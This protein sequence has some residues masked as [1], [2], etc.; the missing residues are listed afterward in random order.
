MGR[1][2]GALKGRTEQA[3]DFARWLRRITSGVKVRSLEEEFPYGK[4]SWS[5]FR[6][7]TRL[8][9]RGLVEQVAARYLPE[10]VMRGRQLEEGLRLLAAAQQ[11]A[12]TPAGVADLPMPA[13]GPRRADTVHAALLRLDDARLRQ[14]EAMQKLAASER[15]REQL[16]D[17]VSALQE[18]CTLLESERDRARE[19]VQVELQHELQLSLEYRRQADEKLEHAR[20]AEEKAYSLRL[21]TEQQVAIER[22]ALRHIDPVAFG[23]GAPPSEPSL[24]LAEELNLPPLEQIQQLLEAA[25]EQLDAQDEELDELGEQIGLDAGDQRSDE[26][27]TLTRIVP[28]QVL[29]RDSDASDRNAAEHRLDNTGKLLTSKDVSAKAAISYIESESPLPQAGPPRDGL[30]TESAELLTGLDTVRT[31]TALSGALSQL[32]NRAGRQSL[33]SLTQAAFPGRLKD[34]LVY[35]TVMRWI[36]GDVLPSSWQHLESLVRVMG[37]SDDE[38][39]AFQQAYARILDTYPSALNTSRDLADLAPRSLAFSDLLPRRGR[40]WGQPRDWCFAFV[41]PS[42]TAVLTTGYT[43]GLQTSSTVD[44]RKLVGYGVL[45]VLACLLAMLVSVG[46]AMPTPARKRLTGTTHAAAFGL[47][48]SL[49]AI[50]AGLVTPWVV[51]SDA[52]GRW[53]AELTGLVYP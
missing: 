3:N 4:S 23:N 40:P 42:V 22:M 27:V 44:D 25:Q 35:M 17:M 29:G 7:G 6:D 16:E 12:K 18:R 26:R 21:A 39:Q 38:V 5:G 30:P 13:P 52:A 20:R 34:D 32:L 19:D 1:P 10:P 31:P 28:G 2:L 43:A 49:L 50:P 8:P 15:R 47:W 14:I 46:R 37:A 36:D 33:T 11:A 9:P 24:S 41:G 48:L 53:L 45:C 51:G